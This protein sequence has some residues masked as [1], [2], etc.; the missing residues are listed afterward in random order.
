MCKILAVHG[1]ELRE[2][3]HVPEIADCL[4]YVAVIEAAGLQDCPEVFA[5]TVGLL[6]DRSADQVAGDRVKRELGRCEY[7]SV[8]FNCL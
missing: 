3:I 5:D 6:G 2:V 1:I 8:F 7:K 4:Q